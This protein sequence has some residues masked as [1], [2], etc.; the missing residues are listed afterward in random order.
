[1]IQGSNKFKFLLKYFWNNSEI[2][3]NIFHN[4]LMLQKF[5]NI[6]SLLLKLNMPLNDGDE[7]HSHGYEWIRQHV[8]KLWIRWK[9]QLCFCAYWLNCVVYKLEFICISKYSFDRC[10]W[11]QKGQFSSLNK[12]NSIF[13]TLKCN[14]W[15]KWYWT[16]L[17]GNKCF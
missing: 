14:L 1:M 9:I 5:Q 11:C 10:W 6:F 4:I 16:Q 13:I 7:E 17:N 2:E 8:K 3:T 15:S 12:I